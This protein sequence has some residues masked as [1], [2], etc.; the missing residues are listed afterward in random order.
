MLL[1][2]INTAN[3]RRSNAGNE[4]KVHMTT[5]FEISSYKKEHDNEFYLGVNSNCYLFWGVD[6]E[7]YRVPAGTTIEENTGKNAVITS[8][9]RDSLNAELRIQLKN[10]YKPLVIPK[11]ACDDSKYVNGYFESL[12]QNSK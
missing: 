6:G 7:K 1:V 12:H 2:T 10:S 9:Y 4:T 8:I 5:T 3:E 11:S